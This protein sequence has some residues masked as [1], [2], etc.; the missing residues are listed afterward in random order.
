MHRHTTALSAATHFPSFTSP[1]LPIPFYISCFEVVSLAILRVSS[2]LVLIL[3]IWNALMLWHKNRVG[4]VTLRKQWSVLV[5]R[6]FHVPYWSVRPSWLGLAD[7]FT[8]YPFLLHIQFCITCK[9]SIFSWKWKW[10]KLLGITDTLNNVCVKVRAC[11]SVRIY[12]ALLQ[13]VI[14]W[15]LTKVCFSI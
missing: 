1:S 12:E 14:I 11:V 13:S 10:L 5:C 4:P 7:L 8:L 6:C 3:S 15:S 9:L 2:D